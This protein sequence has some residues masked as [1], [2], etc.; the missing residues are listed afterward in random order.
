MTSPC[1]NSRLSWKNC[2][3]WHLL[4]DC[5]KDPKLGD[6]LFLT[7]T[8][9]PVIYQGDWI[10]LVGNESEDGRC[11]SHCPKCNHPLEVHKK[12]CPSCGSHIFWS[13]NITP[14]I[15]HKKEDK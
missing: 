8:C 5:I 13:K 10:S 4:N 2:L 6:M 1:L 11:I 7:D 12:V 14:K 9:E 15:W 3:L